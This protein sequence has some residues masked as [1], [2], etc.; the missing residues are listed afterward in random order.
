MIEAVFNFNGVETLLQCN[1]KDT[2]L[3]ICNQFVN[4]LSADIIDYIFYMEV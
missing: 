1:M 3:N 4:K 2:L